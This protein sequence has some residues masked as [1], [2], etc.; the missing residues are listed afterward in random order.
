MSRLI[1]FTGL[2]GSGKS[3]AA[4]ALGE[5][6]WMRVKFAD[7]LKNML[8]AFYHSC[9]VDDVDYIEARI[10]GSLKEE[11]CHFLRGRS[12]RHAMQTL[13]TDWGRN[14][15]APDLWV[16]AWQYRA[17]S[18]LHQG[19]DVVTDDCRFANEAEAVR[20]MG[21]RVVRIIGRG[22]ISGGHA[23]EKMDFEP[24]MVITNTGSLSG[25]ERDIVHVFDRVFPSG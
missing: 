9:G 7:V 20:S 6:G 16:R 15:I 4:A 23:S 24:D 13:G 1:A 18:F 8:R 12:P 19:I 17:S 3:T 11:P 14:C 25:F 10:E 2:A 22:G 21:G 5:Q